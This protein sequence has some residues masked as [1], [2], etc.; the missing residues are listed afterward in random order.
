LLASRDSVEEL[1]MQL[2]DANEHIEQLVASQQLMAIQLTGIED[3]MSSIQAKCCALKLDSL[4]GFRSYAEKRA[5]ALKSTAEGLCQE[6]EATR[7]QR[8]EKDEDIGR[9]SRELA[10]SAAELAITKSELRASAEVDYTRHVKRC[11]GDAGSVE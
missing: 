7:R 5:G 10:A 6:L 9:L 4:M 11:L 2:K 1:S 8:D 3:Y